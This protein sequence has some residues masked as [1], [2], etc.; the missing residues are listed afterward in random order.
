MSSI[1]IEVL[2]LSPPEIPLAYALPMKVF[3][4]FSISRSLISWSTLSYLNLLDPSS[5]NLATKRKISFGVNVSTKISC[6]I[7]KAAN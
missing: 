4:A 7:T 5:L 2:F 3:Y 6:Y 1:A